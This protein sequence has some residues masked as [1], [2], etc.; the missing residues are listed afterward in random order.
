MPAWV[1]YIYRGIS[2]AASAAGGA[3]S[4]AAG[5]VS[6][7]AE[8]RT[9]RRTATSAAGATTYHPRTAS[10][11]EYFS[12]TGLEPQRRGQGLYLQPTRFV[13]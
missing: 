11:S 8:H 1:G 12:T 13:M 3:A 7:D 6:T 4:D 5:V 2:G 10:V 9:H